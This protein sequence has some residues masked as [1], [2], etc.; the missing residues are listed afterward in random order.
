[1]HG[2]NQLTLRWCIQ[3]RWSRCGSPLGRSRALDSLQAKQSGLEPACMS[4]LGPP[5]ACRTHACWGSITASGTGHMGTATLSNIAMHQAAQ[6][7]QASKSHHKP[8]QPESR[9]DV[10]RVTNVI[11]ASHHH[12]VHQSTQE[13]VCPGLA[14]Q[15][16][17]DKSYVCL[18]HQQRP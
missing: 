4:V 9:L 18:L 5:A 3:N 16:K 12:N 10:V 6:V 13:P 11:G 2:S 8:K 7:S 15:C 17:H 1:M 14:Y